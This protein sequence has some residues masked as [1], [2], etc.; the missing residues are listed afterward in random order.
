MTEL[1]PRPDAE[2]VNPVTSPI[3]PDATAVYLK[4]ITPLVKTLGLC[5]RIL[6]AV[7]SH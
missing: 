7:L 1:F 5:N 2:A 6:V 3:D 4:V